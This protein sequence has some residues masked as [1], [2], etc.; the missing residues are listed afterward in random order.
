MADKLGLVLIDWEDSAQPVAAWQYVDDI[1]QP[2]VVQCQS[3][4]FLIYDGQDVKVLAPNM[5]DLDTEHVQ[6]SGV[7]RI[8]VRSITRVRRLKTGR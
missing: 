2:T 1:A 4:G 5:G 3:V 8:P 6:A 7:I